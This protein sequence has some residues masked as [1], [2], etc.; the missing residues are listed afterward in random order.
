MKEFKEVTELIPGYDL[1]NISPPGEMLLFDIETTGLKKE[2]TQIYLIGCGYF[3][4]D[5]AF[6]VRQWLAESAQD[7]REVLE[8][9]LEFA[10]GF[11]VL[12]HF[13]GDGFDIPYTSY[14]IDYYGF[15]QDLYG[16]E[17]VDIYKLIKPYKKL[18]GLPRMNQTSV[19]GFLQIER[20]DR[21]NG[22]LLI[23]YYY[24]YER[25][26]D[27]ECEHLLLLHNSDDVKGMI[28]LVAAL[29]YADIFEGRYTFASSEIVNTPEKRVLVLEYTLKNAVPVSVS[30][31][32][33]GA[34][35]CAEGD[36]LQVNIDIY[37]G[38]ARIPVN[39]IQ[40]YYYL[41]EE[42]RIIH[43]DVAQ[44]VDKKFRKKATK[45]NCFL[46]KTG[47]F[48]PSYGLELLTDGDMSGQQ[49]QS[50]T[51]HC[52]IPDDRG[53]LTEALE[54]DSV[55]SAS[56]ELKCALGLKALLAAI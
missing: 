5:G 1:R 35:V 37:D 2:T 41:P 17:S 38:E 45:N 47:S 11:S 26:G 21:M 27:P 49:E 51:R 28:Q 42:D 10:S 48:I 18:F 29:A 4:E 32:S 34:F 8:S 50:M 15:D 56:S 9:F 23:P 36:L 24:E 55:L 13:N 25:T 22:G 6:N 16:M 53:K 3:D 39:N 40:D 43:K 30:T 33:R 54:L 7:E 44:F 12:V 31:G 20:T 14:K 52:M 19:E 46:K